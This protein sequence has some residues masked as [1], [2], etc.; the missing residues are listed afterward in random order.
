MGSLSQ[1]A[2]E[3]ASTPARK[4]GVAEILL[5]CCSVVSLLTSCILW[6]AHKQVWMDEIFTWREVSDRSL[7]HLYFAIQHGADGGQPL[8]YTTAWLWAKVFG[9]GVLSLR[10]YSSIAMCGSLLVTWLTMRRFYGLWATAFG[11]LVFWGSS[12]ALLEQNVE[13]RFYGLYMLMLALSFYLYARLVTTSSTSLGLLVA[14]FLAQIA[15]VWTHVLGVIYSGLIL[16]ALILV[17]AAKERPRIRVYASFVAGWLALAFWEPAI[18]ASMAAGKP[19]GWIEMPKISD[20]RA[21]YLFADSLQWLKFFKLHSLETGFQI[22]KRVPELV[23]YSS[24][25]VVF[26]YGSSRILKSGWRI[27]STP[28][29]SVLLLAFFLL[30]APAVLFTLSHALT[31]VFVTRYFLPSGIGLSIVLATAAEA[32]GSDRQSRFRVHRFAWVAVILLLLVWPVL[33]VW[34]VGS[35]KA[36][37]DYLDVQRLEGEIPANTVL[38]AAWQEDFVKLMRLGNQPESKYFYLLDWSSALPGPRAFVL[39]YHLMQAYRKVG[40]YAGNIKDNSDFL[41]SHSDFLV[42]DAPNANTLE[43]SRNSS[44]DMGRPNWFDANIRR[45]PQFQ[46]KI[47]DTLNSSEVARKLIAVHRQGALAMCR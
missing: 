45:A 14:V 12:G 23:I 6:T 21:A 1:V 32:L 3:L 19:H 39:D 41:C 30:L 26:L 31:P 8:F 40:Y 18:R 28:R 16:A 20:L 15:L 42:L 38:V 24:L 36:S 44:P 22:F 9:A 7:W 35:I 5:L 2:P 25:V 34:A 10:L 4:T 33:T 37:W 17:D 27:I 29:G 43:G 13:A 47:L 46:W 11:V